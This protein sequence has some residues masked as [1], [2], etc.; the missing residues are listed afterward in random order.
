MERVRDRVSGGQRLKKKKEKSLEG[1]N[2]ASKVI[3]NKNRSGVQTWSGHI[4]LLC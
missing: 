3:G 4:K 1:E 2:A